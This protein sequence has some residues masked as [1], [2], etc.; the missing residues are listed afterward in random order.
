MIVVVPTMRIATPARTTATTLMRWPG[1]IWISVSA[2][3]KF[4]A[5]SFVPASGQ[6][7]WKSVIRLKVERM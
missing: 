7:N 2:K 6:P 5:A 4:D 1:Q 3:A